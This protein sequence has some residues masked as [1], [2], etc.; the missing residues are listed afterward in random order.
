MIEIYSTRLPLRALRLVWMALLASLLMAACSGGQTP[1]TAGSGSSNSASCDTGNSTPQTDDDCGEV[2]IGL[3]DAEGDFVTY[4]VNVTSLTLVRSDGLVVETLPATARVDFAQYLELTE[5]VAAAAIPPGSYTSGKIRLDYSDAEIF[6]EKGAEISAAV[7]LGQNGSPLLDAEFEIVLDSRQQLVVRRGIPALLT[8]DFDLG[9][10]HEVNLAA[11]PVTATAEPYLLAEVDPVDSKELRLRGPLL[12]VDTDS[13][14]Y[15]IGVRPFHLRDGLFGRARIKT[16]A[17][18]VFEIDGVTFEGSAGLAAMAELQA[19]TA[20]LAFGSLNILTRSY[21]AATVYAGSSVPGQN[22]DVVRGNVIKREGNSLTVRGA[23]FVPAQGRATF[24]RTAT[25]TISDATKVLKAGAHD[26][27]L[28]ITDISVGQR[29]NAFGSASVSA[30]TG[31]LL[32]AS[33]GR[34]RLLATRLEGVAKSILPGQIDVDLRSIDRRPTSIF[35]FAG[36]GLSTAV[37]AD[38]ANYEI[39]TGAMS[40][41][42]LSEG[43]AVRV[44]GF[45]NRFGEAPPDFTARSVADYSDSRALL[46]IGWGAGGTAAPFA[47]LGP[48]GILLDLGNPEIG[49]RHYLRQGDVFT[50][51]LDLSTTPL[52]APHPERPGI[53]AIR[54]N[55]KIWIHSDFAL[56]ANDLAARLDGS[57]RVRGM[58]ARGGYR[59]G[60]SL[61]VASRIGVL[62]D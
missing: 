16:D 24:R 59:V 38:P 19:G 12:S 58:Y 50:D 55:N 11:T 28:S 31:I 44:F 51:L 18:T 48:D 4:A 17:N 45:V 39:A 54:Q 22:L 60:A 21:L 23:T 10:S 13:S 20:T 36:T 43:D 34:V 3:T 1:V 37:D 42:E 2:V 61:F 9:A 52:I 49:A 41:A 29:I 62:L 53:F 25:V 26:G 35:D 32:D 14:T 15:L 7:V 5:F 6:V 33:Q 30:D 40:N 56:F 57:S 8:I 46:A 47:S 27:N